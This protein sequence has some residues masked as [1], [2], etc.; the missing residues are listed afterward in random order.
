MFIFQHF[1]EWLFPTPSILKGIETMSSVQFR[2][3]IPRP[4]A[5]HLPSLASSPYATI[6]IANYRHP[7]VRQ[8]IWE[9]KYQGN[10]SVAR[11]AASLVAEEIASIAQHTSKDIVIIPLPNSKKRRRERGWN[12]TELIAQYIPNFYPQVQI[13]TNILR[14]I[15]HTK[16]QATLKSHARLTNLTNSFSIHHK[17]ERKIS[18]N[19]LIVLLDD[20]TTTG[21]TFAEAIK[22][23]AALGLTDICCLAIAH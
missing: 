16:P 8:A 3:R 11:L 2:L 12:Q 14:K 7:F 4:R 15:R 1:L 6:A 17:N 9:L 23:L 22:P 18:N 20:V 19:S 10:V 5:M 21:T 13:C